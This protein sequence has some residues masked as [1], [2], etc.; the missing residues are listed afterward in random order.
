M[1]AQHFIEE[2]MKQ[3]SSASVV[4]TFTTAVLS[5]LLTCLVERHQYVVMINERSVMRCR[6]WHFLHCFTC[7]CSTF[8]LNPQTPSGQIFQVDK[9]TVVF[10]RSTLNLWSMHMHV[11]IL[12]TRRCRWWNHRTDSTR[13]ASVN[14]L[15]IH[16]NVDLCIS[17]FVLVEFNEN[18]NYSLV[19]SYFVK[20]TVWASCRS[21][22]P[23]NKSIFW[24]QTELFFS[25]TVIREVCRATLFRQET[26]AQFINR[27]RETIID[28][29]SRVTKSRPFL[30]SNGA[31]LTSASSDFSEAMFFLLICFSS[32]TNGLRSSPLKSRTSTI[33]E[34]NKNQLFFPTK[35]QQQPHFRSPSE[36][37]RFIEKCFAFFS[38]R[39]K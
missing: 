8:Y 29:S 31:L 2:L 6:Q 25:L 17:I 39:R 30:F 26:A 11:V 23:K 14:F 5:L 9:R 1:N 38:S 21:T 35:C 19:S 15:E 28:F 32:K 22:T 7:K 33:D 20:M 3:K 10:L 34:G 12:S 13:D 37:I 18:G 27:Q 24:R 16:G 36:A 4:R